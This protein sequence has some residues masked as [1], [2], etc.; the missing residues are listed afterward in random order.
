MNKHRSRPWRVA[1]LVMGALILIALGCATTRASWLPVFSNVLVVDDPV[2]PSDVVIVLS[3]GGG[4]QR[5]D[6]AVE[7]YRQGYA[8]KL[9][10]SGGTQDPEGLGP[11][12]AYVMRDEALRLGIPPSDILFEDQSTSTV[13]QAQI[14]RDLLAQGGYTSVILVTDF[15]HSR[16]AW[17]TFRTILRGTGI[18]VSSSPARPQSYGP[19]NWW[20]NE[21]GLVFVQNEYIKTLFYW[22]QYGISPF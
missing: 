20:T 17:N 18:R 14:A 16:R 8:R 3:G 2:Q 12:P 6:H 22:V 1:L 13:E 5:F 9:M 10:V 15:Y 11:R 21:D 7:L 4:R 19:E